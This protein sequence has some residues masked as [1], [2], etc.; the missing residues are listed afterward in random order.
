M[1]SV[2]TDVRRPAANDATES[3]HT[4]GSRPTRRALPS[5]DRLIVRDTASRLGRVA[6]V[7]PGNSCLEHLHY[8]RIRLD[9][10]VPRAGFDC[11]ARET[12]LLCLAGEGTVSVDGAAIAIGQYDGIYVPR[13]SRVEVAT[14]Q[15]L[16]LVEF[17]AEVS[18]SYPLQIV[19]YADVERDPTLKF[20]TGAPNARRLLSNVF[21]KNVQA[22]RI[23]GG[24][25]RSDPGNWTSWPPHEHADILEELYLFFDM[26]APAFGV[27]F[28]YTDRE[29]PEFAQAV[30][31]GDAVLMPAG[32]HPNVAIPG[33]S[34]SFV[35]LMA[36]R[37]EVEDRRFGV[38]N[39]QGEFAAGGSGLE[40]ANRK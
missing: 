40:A 21:G 7:T 22:G 15:H 28:V 19:R 32:Y 35:W 23:L 26:P 10:T 1:N 8:G 20:A 31:D 16:D 3:G 25:T 2:E 17:S 29:S 33:Y 39:V 11:G 24:F 4:G 9:A 36:A 13:G 38:V 18:G 27:Q 34:V 30:R 5:P 6:W 14:D 37:R 12:G